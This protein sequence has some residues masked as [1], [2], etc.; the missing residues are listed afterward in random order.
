MEQNEGEGVG[1]G[2]VEYLEAEFQ[3]CLGVW[4]MTPSLTSSNFP[5]REKI[6]L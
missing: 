1:W 5:E 3:L 6:W 4:L 2:W